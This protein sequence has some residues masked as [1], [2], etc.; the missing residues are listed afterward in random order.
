[1]NLL[2]LPFFDGLPSS[3]RKA[4]AKAAITRKLA[5]G[6]ALI[7]EGARSRDLFLVVSGRLEIVKR[8]ADSPV[9]H[10]IHEVATGEPA[11]EISFFDGG[12]R[13]ATARAMEPTV[14]V[15]LP[16]DKVAEEP[17]LVTRLAERL[18]DRLRHSSKDELDAAQRR[19]TMGALIVKVITLL[20]GYAL[21]VAAL[22]GLSLASTSTT[23]LSLPLIA[24]F[25]WGAWRFIRSTHAPLSMFGL[26]FRNFISSLL[27]SIVL[28]P[29]FCALLVALKWIAMRVHEPW[30]ELPLFERT[31]WA[32]R[33]T[34]P[35]VVK[36]LIVY[37]VSSA[38]Q[39]MIVRSALQASLEEF[40]VG[41]HARRTTLLVCALMFAVNHLHMSFFFAAL[42]FVPGL[43]WGYLFSRRRHLVGPVVSHFVVGAFVFFVLGVSLP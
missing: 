22:P 15:M 28:T 16:H 43:F 25:G 12:P 2:D 40:L 33:L 31:D 39:E 4:L 21:L 27:E 17:L 13:S 36:L 11:G 37:L 20:C 30:R 34:E 41:P 24:A 35:P 14:V 1:V 23:Y 5:A 8:V 3:A 29:P 32:V 9:E 7:E 6:E 19:A 38:V 10:R 26:G 42:V 18:A